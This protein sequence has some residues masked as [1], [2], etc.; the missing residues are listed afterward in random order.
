MASDPFVLDA[1]AASQRKAPKA[2]LTDWIHLIRAEYLEIPGLCLTAG[3]V[4]RL[5]GLD[6]VDCEALLGAL[7]DG[8]FL[9]CSRGAYLRADQAW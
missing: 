3:Q 7:V 1:G 9:K 6:A 2:T 8:K 5:W 4:Q